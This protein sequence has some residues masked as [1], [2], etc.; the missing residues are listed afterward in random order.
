METI[1]KEIE[2]NTK[3]ALVIVDVQNDFVEGGALGVIGGKAVADK[4]ASFVKD[5]KDDLYMVITTRDWHIDPG[6]HFETWPVHCVANTPGAEVLDV[7]ND[8]IVDSDLAHREVSKGLYSDGYS[9]LEGVD[10]VTQNPLDVILMDNNIT[11]I[12]VV[13]IATDHCV[14]ATALDANKKKWWHPVVLTDLIAG[15][16]PEAS[17]AALVEM[18]EDGI[19]LTTSNDWNK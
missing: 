13:G 14:K 6:K 3:T 1:Y 16:D 2:M 15:V 4:I 18:E 7:I 12:V 10:L 11:R 19:L 8:A 5:N 17:A 9:G